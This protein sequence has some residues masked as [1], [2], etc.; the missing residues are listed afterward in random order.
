MNELLETVI[1]AH[2]QPRSSFAG[3]APETSWSN[4][5]LAYFVGTAMWTYLTQPFTFS[6]IAFTTTDVLETMP[7]A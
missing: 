5:Q 7:R 2:D 1:E 3:H 6:L 4:L